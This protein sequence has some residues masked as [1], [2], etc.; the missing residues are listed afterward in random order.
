MRWPDGF[1]CPKCGETSR[2]LRASTH[3][4]WSE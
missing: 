2:F 3:D 4:R 1:V